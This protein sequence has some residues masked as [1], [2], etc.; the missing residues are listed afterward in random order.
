MGDEASYAV[1]VMTMAVE[2]RAS[3]EFR[4]L[5]AR[6]LAL[7]D[8]ALTGDDGLGVETRAFSGPHLTPGVGNY[9]PLDFLEIGLAEKLGQVSE[10]PTVI[11]AKAGIHAR[12]WRPI[13]TP[14]CESANCSLVAILGAWIPLGP[15]GARDGDGHHAGGDRQGVAD[16]SV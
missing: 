6:A 5:A 13:V 1:G 14:S 11:P 12:W 2:G 9:A 16:G 15:G 7:F 4:S 3:A 10:H 8:A